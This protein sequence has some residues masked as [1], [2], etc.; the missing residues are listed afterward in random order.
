MSGPLRTSGARGR[1]RAWLVPGSLA[2]LTVALMLVDHAA[3]PVL[4]VTDQG[5][6]ESRDWY[7]LLRVLGYA[8][9]W[10][11][12][13]LALMLVDS[14]RR[15]SE[16]GDTTDGRAGSRG[17]VGTSPI[18]SRGP[19]VFASAAGAGLLAEGLKL[20]IRRGRP[21]DAPPDAYAWVPFAHGTF[22]S[23]ELGIPSSHAAVAFGAAFALAR[24]HPRAA[25]VL[26]PLAV[27]CALTRAWT[28]QHYLSDLAGG[29]LVGWIVPAAITALHRRR[30]RVK[31]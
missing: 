12:V 14:G 4:R 16:L 8:P 10:L 28:G 5:L 25:W 6:M 30:H 24:L 15:F 1:G 17:D 19:F 3:V 29:A 21:P 7:R 22:D 9:T 26:L 27:G 23:S 31:T 18:W 11:G 2:A 20:V 13:A